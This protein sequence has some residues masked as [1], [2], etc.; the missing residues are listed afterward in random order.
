LY[1]SSTKGKHTK[2]G[3]LRILAKRKTHCQSD[4]GFF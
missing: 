3:D 4:N 2:M 1:S